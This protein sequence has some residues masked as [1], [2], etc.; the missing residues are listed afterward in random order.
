MLFRSEVPEAELVAAARYAKAKGARVILNV[1]PAGA[2]PD[3]LLA[4]LDVLIMNEHEVA[5]VAKGLDFLCDTP[6][7][8]A[9][10]IA[11]NRNL[12]DVTTLADPTVM[13]M[14]AAGLSAPSSED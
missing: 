14:I 3:A 9:R 11:E 6:E 5:A 7:N 10:M 12:G 2:V 8:N 1:A 4:H 13:S